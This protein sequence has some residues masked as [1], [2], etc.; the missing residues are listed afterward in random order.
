MGLLGKMIVKS[1]V[2]SVAKKGAISAGVALVNHVNSKEAG[3]VVSR[4]TATY[5]MMAIKKRGK[6]IIKDDAEKEKYVMKTNSKG[7]YST[8]YDASDC[9]IARVEF[10]KKE[11]P[12][13]GAYRLYLDGRK[14]GDV[15]QKAAVKVKLD[16]EFNGWHIESGGS[17]TK[18]PVVD[19]NGNQ[20][21]TISSSYGNESYAIEYSNVQNE[22]LSLML[23]MVINMQANQH[24]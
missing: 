13:F 4:S 3:A 10:H 8:L 6:F 20:I 12:Y 17:H 1:V 9:E 11:Y 7:T 21:M 14:L 2:K 18:F 22:L 16:V 19:K 23:V 15:L 24:D 5:K